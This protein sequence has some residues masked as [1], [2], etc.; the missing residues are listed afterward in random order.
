M[1]HMA[2]IR[3]GRSQQSFVARVGWVDEAQ[4][5]RQPVGDAKAEHGDLLSCAGNLVQR[6]TVAVAAIDL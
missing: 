2:V 1:A 5:V 4:E 6:S 3:G